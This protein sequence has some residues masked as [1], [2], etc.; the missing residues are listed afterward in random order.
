[1]LTVQMIVLTLCASAHVT[2]QAY[3]MPP[4]DSKLHIYAL[5]V[6]QGDA[7]V[8]QCP[9]TF[10][11]RVTIVDMGSSSRSAYMTNKEIMDFF[12]ASITKIDYVYLTHGDRDHY[13]IL[14]LLN[15]QEKSVKGVFIGCDISD[16]RTE[17]DR[18]VYD[19][20]TKVNG[21]GKLKRFPKTGCTSNCN[22]LVQI[23][24]GSSYIYM[25]V[26]GANLDQYDLSK[27]CANGDSLVVQLEYNLFKLLLP[28][29]LEDYGGFTYDSNGYITSA[30]DWGKPGNLRLFLQGWANPTAGFYRLAHHGTWPNGNKPFFLQGIQVH[31]AF[32]SSKL[33]GT[34]GTF[35]HPNCELYYE[36]VRNPMIPIA[37]ITDPT[38]LQKEYNC[39][40]QGDRYLE[41]N[42][43][44]GMYTTAVCDSK[45]MFHNYVIKIDTDGNGN[46]HIGPVELAPSAVSC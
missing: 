15:I 26:M 36:M 8:I 43:L 35:N 30:S 42:N 1:M 5:P 18:K 9:S 38:Q 12:G 40:Y 19:W 39:G 34:P 10:G 2:M 45:R 22:S 17:R 14:P 16:Y 41:D 46:D 44:W 4:A 6:G 37:K 25:R 20:L 13:N 7:T 31:Y 21:L 3:V 27:S 24:G 28:G 33:P 32:S 11:G 29:D 23:C